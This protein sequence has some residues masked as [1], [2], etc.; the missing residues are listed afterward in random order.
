[1][2]GRE[3][4]RGMEGRGDGTDSTTYRWLPIVKK[5]EGIRVEEYRGITLMPTLYKICAMLSA[6]RLREDVERKK[7]VPQNQTGFRRGMEMID[8]IYVLNYLVNRQI[9]KKG[10]EMLGFFIDLRAAFDRVNRKLLVEELR[11]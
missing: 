11:R 1:M 8:N 5:R 4:A 6:V 2:E 7:I 10:K 9:A 3:V